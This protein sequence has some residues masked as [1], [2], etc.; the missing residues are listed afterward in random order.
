MLRSIVRP[1]L[2]DAHPLR[3]QVFLRSR[4]YPCIVGSTFISSKNYSGRFPLLQQFLPVPSRFVRAV[5]GTKSG[6]W[7]HTPAQEYCGLVGRLKEG[8]EVG[9]GLSRARYGVG[10][11]GSG[12]KGEWTCYSGQAEAQVR[13]MSSAIKNRTQKIVFADVEAPQM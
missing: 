3:V 7:Q 9:R 10:I 11:R 8:F 12:P 5:R 4:A 1:I 2:C 6:R 13:W